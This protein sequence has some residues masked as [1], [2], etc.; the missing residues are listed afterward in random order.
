MTN[1]IDI[2]ELNLYCARINSKQDALTASSRYAKEFVNIKRLISGENRY[3]SDKATDA[4]CIVLNQKQDLYIVFQGTDSKQD[5]RQDL[6]FK[7]VPI[8]ANKKQFRV[9]EGMFEQYVSL[10]KYL[11]KEITNYCDTYTDTKKRVVI[12]GHSLGGA[13][14]ILCAIFFHALF[15]KA[16]IEIKIVTIGAPRVLATNLSEWFSKR[17]SPH[18]IRIVNHCD[19]IPNLPIKGPVF[20]YDHPRHCL[21]LYFKEDMLYTKETGPSWLEAC[22]FIRTKGNDHYLSNYLLQIKK[23]NF[24][25]CFLILSHDGVKIIS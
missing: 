3:Y 23:F 25:K 17:L 14:A 16:N 5:W 1:V 6:K 2:V 18:T 11:D 7:T 24:L 20:Q 10:K 4:E 22:H 21:L 12:S 15:E 13:L 19:E 8:F 9:H